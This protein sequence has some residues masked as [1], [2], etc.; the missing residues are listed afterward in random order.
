MDAHD[1][2]RPLLRLSRSLR[3]PG[4]AERR[5]GRPISMPTDQL[6]PEALEGRALMTASLP[7]IAPQPVLGTTGEPA[8]IVATATPRTFTITWAWNENRTI[9]DFNPQADK[10][11]LDWFS[12][13]ELRLTE[14][15]GSAVLSIPAMQQSYRLA[16]VP[17]S[18]L[19]AANFT[20]KDASATAYIGSVLAAAKPAPAPAPTPTPT[21]A[22]TPTPSPTPSPAPT[23]GGTVQFKVTSDWG[24]GFNGD[25]TV[26]NTGTA[27]LSNWSVSFDFAGTISSLWNGTIAGRQGATYTVNAASWNATLAPGASATIGFTANPGGTSAVLTN[28][29][30]NGVAPAPVTLP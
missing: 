2:F 22:P 8:A 17:L 11:A 14:Q 4:R 25:I 21:P 16:G 29:K 7:G 13:S 9:A 1:I 27:T 12:G 18:R 5:R 28:L 19:Q 30:L 3:L 10:L 23:T 24:S 15:S 26:K 20:C 6:A